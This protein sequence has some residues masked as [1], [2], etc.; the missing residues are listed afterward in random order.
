M[1]AMLLLATPLVAMQFTSEVVWKLGD[2]LVF[3]FMFAGLGLLLEGAARIGRNAA[4]RAWLM[5]GAVA[6]FLV[7]WAELAVGLFA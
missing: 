1:F 2:F 5:A 4:M 6:I 7:I 3:A